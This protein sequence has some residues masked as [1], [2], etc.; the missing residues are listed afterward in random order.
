MR[1]VHFEVNCISEFRIGACICAYVILTTPTF[2]S[3]TVRLVSVIAILNHVDSEL[4]SK[5]KEVARVV[6]TK[7]Q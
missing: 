7:P 2:T 3:G 4:F 5:R 6:F 1:L